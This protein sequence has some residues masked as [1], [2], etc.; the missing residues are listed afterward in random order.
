MEYEYDALHSN[1]PDV[2]AFATMHK[3]STLP[4][5]A[6]PCNV[7][8]LKHGWQVL[9]HQ[10]MQK[11]PPPIAFWYDWNFATFVRSQPDFESFICSQPEYIS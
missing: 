7:E 5:D 4:S 6:V 8:D 2:Y 3:V 10:P 11:P 9:D 1:L